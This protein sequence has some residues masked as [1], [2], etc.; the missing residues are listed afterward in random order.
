MPDPGPCTQ[1][2]SSTPMCGPVEILAL[3][4]VPGVGGATVGLAVL[5]I[6]GSGS[7]VLGQDGVGI[8]VQ[9]GGWGALFG[10]EGSAYQ[11]AVSA[12]RA[13]AYA[14]DSMGASTSL[15]A[16]LPKAAGLQDFHG[17]KP[18]GERASK[19]EL[20]GLAKTVGAEA[21]GGDA[22]A[23][24]CVEEQ[25]LQLAV[26]VLANLNRI[27]GAGGPIV[28]FT[29]GG[30]FRNNP[31]F[32]ETFKKTL[33][34]HAEIQVKMVEIWG[35]RAVFALRK[36]DANPP[37]LA[38]WRKAEQ[39]PALDLPPTEGR[40]QAEMTLDGMTALEIVRFMNAEDSRLAESIAKEAETIASALEIGAEAVRHDR[41]IL[42]VGAGTSGR[43]GVL[44]A[45][46]CPPT[47][48]VGHDRVFGIIAGGDQALRRSVEGAED[49][50]EQAVADLQARGAGAGDFVV[51]ISASGTTPYVLAA[52]EEA[53]RLGAQTLLL[54]CNPACRAAADLIIALDT[55]PE[56]LAGSTRLKAGTATKM[57]LNMISTGAMSLAGLVFEGLMVGMAPANRKL[58]GRAVRI[59]TALTK[60]DTAEAGRLLEEADGRIAVAV[61]MARKGVGKER[62]EAILTAAGGNL[63]QALSTN[64]K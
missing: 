36:L 10:D 20:A 35:H 50:C 27:N 56:A 43:L 44:D 46:E 49:D 53:K 32:L 2:D 5:V 59:V 22:V 63:S 26:Q 45:S 42:Y 14:T 16:A 54:C 13:A 41:H 48:G 25:A 9:T 15:R 28:V 17:F 12:L 21:E 47:F 30:V 24:A 57:V 55:G 39:E 3:H 37:W 1:A 31:L 29:H 64:A 61:V 58:R 8:Y 40:V 60:A 34:V 11:I 18:W 51:G 52:L 23:K 7:S 33:A 38:V 19:R 4:L 6:S 62:A